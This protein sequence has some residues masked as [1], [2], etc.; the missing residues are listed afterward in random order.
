MLLVLSPAKSLNFTS[1]LDSPVISAPRFP[2]ETERLV[3]ALRNLSKRQLQDIMPVSDKLIALNRERYA[4]FYAQAQKPAIHAFNGDVYAGFAAASL[5]EA[6][7]N[8]A[9]QHVRILSGL[10]GLL[11]PFDRIRPHRLEMGTRWAPRRKKLTDFWREKIAEQVAQDLADQDDDILINLASQ[12]YWAAVAPYQAR[13]NA[14]IVTIEF[15]RDGPKGPRIISFEAKRAR[16]MMARFVCEHRFTRAEDLQ[17]FDC[18]G[19]RFVAEDSDDHRY[20]FVR[21]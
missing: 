2:E 1:M 3:T 21:A 7:L 20:R 8:F 13:L 5:D 15:L 6:A 9:Q 11:R 17:Q 10:Y 14:R 18:D 12:E 16:G 4:D 19:Y